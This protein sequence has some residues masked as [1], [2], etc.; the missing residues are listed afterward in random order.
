MTEEPWSAPFV[1]TFSHPDLAGNWRKRPLVADHALW[2]LVLGFKFPSCSGACRVSASHPWQ[3]EELKAAALKAK[4]DC[5]QQ[6]RCFVATALEAAF[7]TFKDASSG[8]A[9]LTQKHAYFSRLA[10]TWRVQKLWNMQPKPKV[11]WNMWIL[12]N[13]MKHEKI[14]KLH[15]EQGVDNRAGKQFVIL[16]SS[17]FK[18]ESIRPCGRRQLTGGWR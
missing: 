4:E 1:W 9:S 15:V 2:G 7:Q 10:A 6:A 18:P 13:V 5:P 3:A 8:V 12:G 17:A 11:S 14:W 16:R